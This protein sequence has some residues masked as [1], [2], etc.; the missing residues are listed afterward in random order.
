MLLVLYKVLQTH[1]FPSAPFHSPAMG[2]LTNH[3]IHLFSR[4][5]VEQVTSQYQ[6]RP[7]AR[8]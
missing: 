2:E 5:A 8:N 7:F 6:V 3:V 4:A 1:F